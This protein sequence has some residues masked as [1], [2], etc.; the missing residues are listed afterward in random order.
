MDFDG[1]EQANEA[2]KASLFTSINIWVIDTLKSLGNSDF[3]FFL[4][5]SC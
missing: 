4:Q 3:S 1:A 2:T 5:T